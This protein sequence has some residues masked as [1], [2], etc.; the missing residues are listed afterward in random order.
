MN[1]KLIIFGASGN[2][3]S[4]VLSLLKKEDFD[5]EIVGV[6]VGKNINALKELLREYK[7]IKCA[8]LL[9]EKEGKELQKEFR[10]IKFYS[11]EKGL[12]SLLKENEFD[13]LLNAL[14][15]FSG[16]LPSLEAIKLNKTLLL[17]NKE[18]LVVAGELIKKELKKSKSKIYPIDSEHAALY[19]CLKCVKKEE[20]KNLYLTCS[21]GP[22]FGKSEDELRKVTLK[23][24]LNHPTFKMGKK[25]TIDSST[26]MNKAF[27]I[28]EAYYLF[29]FDYEHIKVLIDRKSYVHSFIELKD[30]NYIL[31]V[32]PASMELPL[33]NALNEFKE[34]EDID[35]KEE[36][37]ISNYPFFEVDKKTFKAIN[38]GE[39][40]IKN[41]GISGLV[42]NAANEVAVNEFLKGNINYFEIVEI[43]DR[44]LKI[45]DY[46]KDLKEE[47]LVILDKLVKEKTLDLIKKG[48]KSW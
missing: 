12:I 43:I 29:D 31:S 45:F 7:T 11:G 35:I 14:V 19:K 25:I 36:K 20:V 13:T 41:K 2:I 24:A 18:S 46:K 17:A 10:D 32:G 22:F 8:Y 48:E 30:K 33:K 4:Q 39:F 16:V 1:K 23:E 47:E 40:I 15:G 3:G 44:I 34:K 6:S 28:V 26:L 9:D 37:D 42:I 27:E 21:G 38:Y 5:Y